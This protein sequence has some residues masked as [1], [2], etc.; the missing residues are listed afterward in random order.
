M[1]ACRCVGY[2]ALHI[3]KHCRDLFGGV[4]RFYLVLSLAQ[5]A[6]GAAAGTDGNQKPVSGRDEVR[7]VWMWSSAV[8]QKG[9]EAVAEQLAGH[10]INRVFF[11][12]KGHSGNVCYPSKVAPASQPEKDLLK[13]IVA[14]CHKR[15]IELHAWYI[16]NG[17]DHWARTHPEDA[18]YHV[19]KADAWA[20]GPYSKKDA[21]QAIPICPLSTGYRAYLKSQIGEVLDGYDVDGVHLD[22]IRYG[23]ACYCFCPKHQATAA[24][25]GVDVAKVRDAV[26]KTFYAPQ[27]QSGLYFDLFRSGDRDITRWV[28]LREQDIDSAVKDMRDLVKSRKPSLTLSAAF[29][30]EG[31]ERDDAYALCHYA[32]S[33]S[34]AGGQLDYILPMTYWNSPQRVA[35]IARNAEQKSHR[36]VYSGLWASEVRAEPP[37]KE[38]QKNSS[39]VA[40]AKAAAS[41]L[42]EDVQTLRERGVK[43][44]VLFQ[45]GTMTERLW[46]EL[47]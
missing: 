13:E 31:G 2:G 42:R 11:L 41:K 34:T 43:G 26:Y 12:V 46:K 36:P 47:P 16:I 30:P 7:G 17:D 44:F 39:P 28:N 27:K 6:L 37:V 5:A 23:H 22:Y 25:N 3:V 8:R 32:Q 4:L 15:R 1:C 9:A 45:Y 35:E 14:A 19:G 20:K 33:Y 24:T 21:P 18:M 10:D 38:G 40:S 29:M